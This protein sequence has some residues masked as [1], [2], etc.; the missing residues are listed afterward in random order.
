[1]RCWYRST[2]TAG[3]T[4][5]V[6]NLLFVVIICNYC[7]CIIL[8]ILI[9]YVFYREKI[10]K[11][12]VTV[13]LKLSRLLQALRIRLLSVT[14]YYKQST[15]SLIGIKPISHHSFVPISHCPSAD[16]RPD[17][18]ATQLSY[19]NSHVPKHRYAACVVA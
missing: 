10:K 8:H 13:C 19:A 9:S 2:K 5:V 7:I 15:H 3:I 12:V 17:A 18:L 16:H 4:F 14:L 1:M 6:K 11:I